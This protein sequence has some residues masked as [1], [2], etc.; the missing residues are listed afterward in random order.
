MSP[1]EERCS[2]SLTAPLR[3]LPLKPSAFSHRLNFTW[4]SLS[5]AKSL[6][7]GIVT[8]DTEP[9]GVSRAICSVPRQRAF[10]M[11]ESC[12]AAV[13]AIP[14]PPPRKVARAFAK[15]TLRPLPLAHRLA[16]STGEC[17]TTLASAS[18]EAA[19]SDAATRAACLARSCVIVGPRARLFTACAGELAFTR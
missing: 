5:E 19:S 1:S 14:V 4:C 13:A 7:C 9:A 2:G 15:P 8:T 10:L 6:R 16:S 3:T 12:F 17:L 11:S 18:L